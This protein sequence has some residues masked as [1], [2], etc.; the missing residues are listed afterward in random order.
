MMNRLP[1]SFFLLIP[2]LFL[3]FACD[4]STKGKGQTPSAGDEGIHRRRRGDARTHGPRLLPQQAFGHA[5]HDPGEPLAG[6]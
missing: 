3:S 6:E 2:L 5:R 1:Q 4:D